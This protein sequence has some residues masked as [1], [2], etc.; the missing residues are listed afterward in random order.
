MGVQAGTITDANGSRRFQEDFE[1]F[2]PSSAPDDSWYDITSAGSGF[3]LV[4]GSSPIGTGKA[5]QII[6]SG[7]AYAAH[8]TNTK[9]GVSLCSNAQTFSFTAALPDLADTATY[10]LRLGSG[11]VSTSAAPTNSLGVRATGT[12]TA[13][14]N[15]AVFVRGNAGAVQV[16]ATLGAV[17]A[18]T[19]FT[20]VISQGTCT[21]TPSF[22]FVITSGVNQWLKGQTGAAA[23][24]FTGIVSKFSAVCTSLCSGQNAYVDTYDWNGAPI[25]AAADEETVITAQ[26]NSG[27][28]ATVAKVGSTIF[29]IHQ[30][31]TGAV[32]LTKST[33]DGA[34]WTD[35]ATGINP[36]LARLK[37]VAQ[38]ASKVAFTD[39]SSI[40]HSSNG[41][42]SWTAITGLKQYTCAGPGGPFTGQWEKD[43]DLAVLGTTVYWTRIVWNGGEFSSDTRL[44]LV[45]STSWFASPTTVS[46]VDSI[47]NSCGESRQFGGAAIAPHATNGACVIY[48][49]DADTSNVYGEANPGT[50]CGYTFNDP[51]SPV[52]LCG[53]DVMVDP[54]GAYAV[55]RDSSNVWYQAVYASATNQWFFRSLGAAATLG[56]PWPV[57]V[58]T[59]AAHLLLVSP[60][61]ATNYVSLQKA[62]GTNAPTVVPITYGTGDPSNFVGALATDCTASRLIVAYASQSASK[63]AL[64][65]PAY[66]CTTGAGGGTTDTAK[67][68]SQPWF[69]SERGAERFAYNYVE[70]VVFASHN[71]E[72][73]P[74][75]VDAEM[76][77]S[78]LFRGDADD[79]AYMGK[80]M[81]P[82][83]GAKIFFA[84]E[85]DVENVDSVFR[86]GFSFVDHTPYDLGAPNH[87]L[88]GPD[89]AGTNAKGD[90]KDTEIFAEWI[91]VRFLEVGNDWNIAVYY[92]SRAN[93]VDERTKLGQSKI[94]DDPNTPYGYVLTVDTR[95]GQAYVSV[96]HADGTQVGSGVV[97]ALNMTLP[98]ELVDD[99]IQGQ[100][101][102]GYAADTFFNNNAGTFLDNDVDP[103]ASTCIYV[104][105]EPDANGDGVPDTPP[106]IGSAGA[107][108]PSITWTPNGTVP[109]GLA[110]NGGQAG[111]GEDDGSDVGTGFGG[112][113]AGAGAVFGGGDVGGALFIA[114]I[115][116][117]CFA[118]GIGGLAAS[119]SEK[120]AIPGFMLGALLGFGYAVFSDLIPGIITFL[121]CAA[122]VGLGVMKFR[123]ARSE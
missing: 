109:E 44:E 64:R 89:E 18:N 34:T 98:T 75:S 36:G 96:R 24:A 4:S 85:A 73:L 30:L 47:T 16:S 74:V 61:S 116:M 58:E 1:S 86:A 51:V 69:C 92:V 97:D 33:N 80:T 39:G 52:S 12:A 50:N 107:A 40:W 87:Y 84:I 3:N 9:S 29:V 110:P 118:V 114:V 67:F 35:I 120:A 41:G 83:Q 23:D 104:L 71:D 121:L 91:E 7:A 102:V 13:D 42:T 105:E 45:K 88:N 101:F 20:V 103:S 56:T 8:L 27:L 90:G 21:G 117:A 65:T 15:L 55:C 93:D 99:E 37:V 66:T 123:Q 63:L 5:W 31:N 108:G 14:N 38:D 57:P 19:A 94:T 119:V 46:F 76:G 81:N 122:A 17:A 82:T 77:A 25:V 22:L 111:G 106:A 59:Q 70:G 79:F 72:N 28:R 2:T 26:A 48:Q 43:M 60:T 68:S 32:F 113:A 53:R 115:V 95:P 100:W 54:T 78:Y 112:A 62:V 10:E 6:D 49:I 11:A